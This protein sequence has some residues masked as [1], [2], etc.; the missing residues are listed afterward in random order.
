MCL[1]LDGSLYFVTQLAKNI[2]MVVH[3][4]GKLASVIYVF[5]ETSSVS[6]FSHLSLRFRPKHDFLRSVLQSPFSRNGLWQGTENN[7]T[8]V[9]LRLLFISC[10]KK[11]LRRAE[12]QPWT[13][14]LWRA[15]TQ[16]LQDCLNF[17]ALCYLYLLVFA[18]LGSNNQGNI[19][20]ASTL[21][22]T[23]ADCLKG[24]S[25]LSELVPTHMTFQSSFLSLP[26]LIYSLIN[27]PIQKKMMSELWII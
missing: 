27:L 7:S 24:T 3:Y 15:L 11:W 22:R 19:F 21:W 12:V 18:F 14:K 6:G 10:H 23:P 9:K 20:C 2:T 17:S 5:G 25:R 1:S 16:E 4:I 13:A 8:R 26:F